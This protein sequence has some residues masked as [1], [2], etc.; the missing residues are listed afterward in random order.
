MP[1]GRD[2]P[3]ADKPR[4]RQEGQEGSLDPISQ[5]NITARCSDG[6]KQYTGGPVFVQIENLSREEN[7]SA[8]RSRPQRVQRSRERGET[9]REHRATNVEQASQKKHQRKAYRGR[10]FAPMRSH[11]QSDSCSEK[12]S[13]ED[14]GEKYRPP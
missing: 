14:H 10:Q 3:L 7:G 8:E 1:L 13:P 11:E 12:N 2:C 5:E 4:G 6:P 9:V